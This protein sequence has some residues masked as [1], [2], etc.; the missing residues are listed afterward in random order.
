MKAKPANQAALAVRE[1]GAIETWRDPD[2]QRLWLAMQVRP[3]RSLALVPAGKGAPIDFSLRIAVTLARTGMVH[4][5][6]PVQV[7]DATRVPLAYLTQFT[8]EVRRCTRAGDLILVALASIEE[9]P[10]TTSIAQASDAALL[11]VLL[12]HMPSSHA[13]KTV[14]QI[15]APRFVGSAIFHEDQVPTGVPAPA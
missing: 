13:K 3:W 10:L 15:G 9:N 8:E 11:C 6:S 14:A 5:G 12:E 1:T 4:L 7:A 2:W